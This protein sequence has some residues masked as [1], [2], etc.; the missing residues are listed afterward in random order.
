MG[1]FLKK[2]G[3][4]FGR[5]VSTAGDIANKISKI[6]GKVLTGLGTGSR[7]AKDLIG[8]G[9]NVVDKV[10]T[11]AKLFLRTAGD[12]S[13]VATGG[14]DNKFSQAMDKAN[15][16]RKQIIHTIRT[17]ADRATKIADKVGQGAEAVR[18]VVN[19]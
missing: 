13:R 17:G 15:D 19:S 14:K 3:K 1:G 4:S 16:S 6:G 2:I 8:K 10:N 12:I 18:N 11:G 7:V 9:R 5:F